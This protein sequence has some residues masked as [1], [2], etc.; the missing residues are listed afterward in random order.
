ML[1]ELLYR[2]PERVELEAA[3]LAR[4]IRNKYRCGVRVQKK[5][6]KRLGWLELVL[7]RMFEL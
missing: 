2:L 1:T 3:F 6:T 5:L 7:D 4:H